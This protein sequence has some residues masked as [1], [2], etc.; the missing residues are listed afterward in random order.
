[1]DIKGS[2]RMLF[3]SFIHRFLQKISRCWL[4]VFSTQLSLSNKHNQQAS[5]RQQNYFRISLIYLSL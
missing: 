5:R 3:R 4:V 1:M 2:L